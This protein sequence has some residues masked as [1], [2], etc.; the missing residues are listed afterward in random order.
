MIGEPEY[1]LYQRINVPMQSYFRPSKAVKCCEVS[2]VGR[3][4][5]TIRTQY[6]EHKIMNR[7]CAYRITCRDG[8]NSEGL[9]RKGEMKGLRQHFRKMINSFY[10]HP[11]GSRSSEEALEP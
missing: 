5:Q 11:R 10:T 8:R 3:L 1:Q 2:N 7:V 9:R 4:S 6:A